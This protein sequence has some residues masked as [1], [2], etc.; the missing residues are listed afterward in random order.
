MEALEVP[1]NNPKTAPANKM[2]TTPETMAANRLE[3]TPEKTP[4]NKPET[5]PANKT[6]TPPPTVS[7]S[8]LGS[9]RLQ[10]S[11]LS[12][13]FAQRKKS[14]SPAFAVTGKGDPGKN[15][16]ENPDDCGGNRGDYNLSTI[17]L[18]ERVQT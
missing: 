1:A 3:T 11:R 13:Y 10:F 5:T 12:E 18:N 9:N 7:T 8:C 4:A 2:E 15:R 6:E 14:G 16:K 17:T